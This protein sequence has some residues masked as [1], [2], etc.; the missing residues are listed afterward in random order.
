M[1]FRPLCGS[2]SVKL[3]HYCGETGICPPVQRATPLRGVGPSEGWVPHVGGWGMQ[4]SPAFHS[5]ARG[6]GALARGMRGGNL[7]P[8]PPLAR[9]WSP[10]VG[11]WEAEA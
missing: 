7:R 2:G 1:I 8:S 3:I 4:A 5:L 11:G 9:V 6:L 10:R